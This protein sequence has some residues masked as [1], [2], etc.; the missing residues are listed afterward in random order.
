MIVAEVKSTRSEVNNDSRLSSSLDSDPIACVFRRNDE[1]SCRVST[2][3][4]FERPTSDNPDEERS[5]Q[6]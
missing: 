4:L 2:V 5:E 6:P 1:A 3:K